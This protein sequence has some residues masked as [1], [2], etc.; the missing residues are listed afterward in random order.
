[1]KAEQVRKRLRQ[2]AD[3]DRAEVTQRFFKTGP[4]EY[5]EGDVFLGVRVP[6]L[7]RLAREFQ[8]LDLKAIKTLLRSAIHEERALALLILL[9]NY[10][11]G[12]DK[13]RE[14]IYTFYMN[15]LRFINNW[16][17]VDL[18]ADHVVG[19]FLKDKSR[20][21]LRKLARSAD[22]WER[23]VSILAT[24]HYIKAGEFSETLQI[25][26]AL[27][28]DEEDLIQKA[29]GWMLR[30]VGKRDLATEERFLREHYRKMP[31]TMLRYAIERFPEAKRQ[32]Y[33][34][35]EV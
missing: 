2:L 11:R 10:Q 9:R 16:D 23:R 18:S 20:N 14:R 25:A 13:E 8:E 12:G 31:R 35:G 29:V 32:S 17:L 19:A 15:H 27:L 7:R 5:G 33:L 34:K 1:M 28:S 4:G 6:D 24:F 21:P 26:R 22:L 30:E 3:R